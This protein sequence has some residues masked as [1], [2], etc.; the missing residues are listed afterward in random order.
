ASDQEKHLRRL[1]SGNVQGTELP[2]ECD[3]QSVGEVEISHK[4]VHDAVFGG[5][6]RKREEDVKEAKESVENDQG[7]G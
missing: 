3:D 7:F 4:E 6:A 2:E 5:P 1:Q